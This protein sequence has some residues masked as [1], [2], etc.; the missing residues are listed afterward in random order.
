MHCQQNVKYCRIKQQVW[1][2][3]KCCRVKM[4]HAADADVKCR[5]LSCSAEAA[6][7]RAPCVIFIDEI[8]SVGA[9]RTNSVLH[10][11]ANQ[12]INQL[13]SEMDGWVLVQNARFRTNIIFFNVMSSWMIM[14]VRLPVGAR[15]FAFLQS[16]W[17]RSGAIQ[18]C[19]HGY[20]GFFLWVWSPGCEADCSPFSTAEVKNEWSYASS[21]ACAIMAC[22]VTSLVLSQ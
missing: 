21:P 18:S 15:Y 8:D 19:I 7:D 17:T 10:P 11:Y 12:T 16:D 1:S 14:G 3:M 20:L 5:V 22:I 2:C 4:A 13:L 6:K 9:K